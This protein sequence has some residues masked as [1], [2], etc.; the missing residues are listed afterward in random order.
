[1]PNN[2]AA[3]FNLLDKLLK[4][5]DQENIAICYE[6]GQLSYIELI[7]YIM[8]MAGFYQSQHFQPKDRI[9]IMLPDGVAWVIAYLGALWAGLIPMGI[10]PRSSLSEF[11]KLYQLALPRLIIADESCRAGLTAVNAGYTQTKV[12][13]ILHDQDLLTRIASLSPV[14]AYLHQPDDELFWVFTSGSAGHPKAIV[15]GARAIEH[16][17]QFAR[18]VLKIQASDRLYA[19]SRLFFAYPLANVLFAAL[20]C[21]ATMVL[22]RAWPCCNTM[23]H[24]LMH[25]KPTLVFSVPILYRQLLARTDL[26]DCL[27]GVRYCVSAGEHLSDYLADT[28]RAASSVPLMNGYGM[29]ETLSFILYGN[30]DGLPGLQKA[31]G[32]SIYS[33]HHAPSRLCFSHPGLYKRH[34]TLTEEWTCTEVYISDDIFIE[35]ALQRFK[36]QC[37]A[38]FLCKVKGRF[39]HLVEEESY[40]LAQCAVELKEIAVICEPNAMGEAQIIWCVVIDEQVPIKQVEEK[41]HRVKQGLPNYR[42][43]AIWRYYKA[44]PRTSTGKILYRQLIKNRVNIEKEGS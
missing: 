18:E 31:P 25:Y 29:S 12:E 32:V 40:V 13:F 19:T 14:A 42:R 44:L 22:H 34:I 3:A 2:N 30:I 39:V 38:D 24:T 43:P 1:M 9:M 41:L 23:A 5:V 16:S 4:Q 35:V 36:F 26:S 21:G 8:K 17:I 28:W 6:E 15:H 37:R 7:S 11:N 10:N 33:A 20:G 27:A